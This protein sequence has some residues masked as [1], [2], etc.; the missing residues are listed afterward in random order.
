MRQFST[1][2]EAVV[3]SEGEEVEPVWLLKDVIDWTSGFYVDWKDNESFIDSVAEL[4]ARWNLEIDWGG[5]QADEEF[6]DATDVPALM[7]TAYDR[8]VSYTHLDVY[9]RQVLF[10]PHA[11]AGVAED[12]PVQPGGLS[13]QRFPLEFLRRGRREH[14]RQRRCH[15]RLPGAVPGRGM[16]DLQDR[17]ETQGLGGLVFAQ[18]ISR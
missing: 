5:D 7:S 15:P 8:P 18:A 13:G 1:Y 6:L 12:H 9:K 4:V 2:R 11:A 16:V 17:V 14:R 3:E 10:H